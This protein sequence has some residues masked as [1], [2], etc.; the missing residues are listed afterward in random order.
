MTI[1]TWLTGAVILLLLMICGL[2][3]ILRKREAMYEERIEEI[4]R[5]ALKSLSR[6]EE[7]LNDK[8]SAREGF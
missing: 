3:F 7:N 4:E 2:W 6:V 8:N 5:E 1:T